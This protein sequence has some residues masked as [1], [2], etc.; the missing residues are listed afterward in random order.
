MGDADIASPFLVWCIRHKVTI[1]QVRRDVEPVVTVC[2]DL[3][4]ACSNNGYA[5]VAHQSTN[6]AVAHIQTDLVQLFGH[7]W[8]TIATKNEPPLFFDMRQCDEI[9]PLSATGWPVAKCA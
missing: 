5:V 1:Q 7:A 8:P 9:R 6:T 4:L 3:V 2:R